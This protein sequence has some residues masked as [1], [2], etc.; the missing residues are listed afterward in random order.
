MR[1][2]VW[3]W[4]V[5]AGIET[6]ED[7]PPNDVVEDCAYGQESCMVCGT[8]CTSVPGT[9]VYCGDAVV[10]AGN[11]EC[12]EGLVNNSDV[13]PDKCR[14]SC[15]LPTCGD[16]VVDGQGAMVIAM[17]GEISGRTLDSMYL[18][19]HADVKCSSCTYGWQGATLTSDDGITGGMLSQ[20]GL[21]GYNVGQIVDNNTATHGWHTDGSS[22]G[23]FLAIDLGANN[24]RAFTKGRIILFKLFW[25]MALRIL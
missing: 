11:E 7:N 3:R 18:M 14:T 17:N 16:G 10:Q 21:S 8:A 12:D 1:H 6:C 19:N 15:V 9:R 22:A 4:W 2:T 25:R 5:A 23:A 20:S 24:A 13:T